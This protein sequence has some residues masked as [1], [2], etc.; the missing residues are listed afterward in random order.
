MLPPP[1]PRLSLQCQGNYSVDGFREEPANHQPAGASAVVGRQRLRQEGGGSAVFL[2]PQRARAAGRIRR[3]VRA[4]PSP[5]HDPPFVFRPLPP[6][7][8]RQLLHQQLLQHS[9]KN[10]LSSSNEAA[11]ASSESPAKQPP[12][13]SFDS[14]AS[15]DSFASSSNAPPEAAPTST[16]RPSSSSGASAS[17]SH[18]VITHGS[19]GAL[20]QV[21]D[22]GS[23]VISYRNGS[24][25]E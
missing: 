5:P 24:S 17:S 1:L 15:T 8:F 3:A 14:R 22:D 12:H 7:C 11:A 21:K 20:E 16:F 4:Q 19:N 25:K 13:R 10:K 6:S 9:A 2:L 18:K 23:R